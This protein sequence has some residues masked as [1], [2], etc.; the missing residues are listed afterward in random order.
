MGMGVSSSFLSYTIPMDFN[1]P[2][3]IFPALFFLGVGL[4]LFLQW[5]DYRFMK[6]RS[7]AEIDKLSGFMF[8]KY[9]SVLFREQ[10][11]KVVVT[12]ERGDFGADL[13]IQ[14]DGVKTAV[15]AKRFSGT[16][17]I[18]AVQQ[19]VGA[20]LH[21]KCQRAMVVT[22]STF[23]PAA[24]KLAASNHVQLIERKKLEEMVKKYGGKK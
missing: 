12:P 5:F 8:E 16:V 15:Q 10:G 21:Y 9:L 11:Y 3:F 4:L 13:V 22:N 14:K 17:G 18:S 20:T 24:W 23:T 7:M 19:V 6:N 2:I 1:F